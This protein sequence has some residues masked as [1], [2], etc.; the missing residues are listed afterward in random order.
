MDSISAIGGNKKSGGGSQTGAK[1]NGTQDAEVSN[2]FGLGF[3]DEKPAFCS[4]ENLTPDKVDL[5]NQIDEDIESRKEE[6]SDIATRIHES[7][8]ENW[9]FGKQE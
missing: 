9:P 2:P 5:C 3:V 4:N 6:R 7:L 8:K 1:A